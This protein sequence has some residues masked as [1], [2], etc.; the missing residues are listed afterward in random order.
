MKFVNEPT[1]TG[2]LIGSLRENA[3]APDKIAAVAFMSADAV[4]TYNYLKKERSSG[5]DGRSFLEII[6][7]SAFVTIIGA[8]SDTS[9]TID[10]PRVR[11]VFTSKH[12]TAHTNLLELDSGK[13]YLWHEPHHDVARNE[14]CFPRGAYLVDV[15][16]SAESEVIR[17]YRDEVVDTPNDLDLLAN[18]PAPHRSAHM[19][20]GILVSL[21]SDWMVF[22]NLVDEW[23]RERGPASSVTQM[24]TCLSYQRIIAMG[25]K[26]IGLILRRLK[27]E[28]EEPDHW[29]W[30]LRV[31]TGENPIPESGRGDMQMMA[32]AWLNWG[33]TAGYGR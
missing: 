9:A 30:A 26:A 25:D 10:D 23:H 5:V 33:R 31:L 20:E 14:D 29:F 15:D 17:Y 2:S 4:R 3:I 32:Q 28:G 1:P 7:P 11:I 16:K 19:N 18:W 22:Q 13:P 12:L 6:S 21:D 24:A 27:E 8:K